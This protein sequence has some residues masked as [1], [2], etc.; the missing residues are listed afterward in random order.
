MKHDLSIHSDHVDNLQVC[1]RVDAAGDDELAGGVDG[2]GAARD[3]IQVLAH[4]LDHPETEKD[5]E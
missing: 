1:V 2:A 4:R 3:P 5:M